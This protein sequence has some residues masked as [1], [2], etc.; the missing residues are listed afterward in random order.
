[1]QQTSD[2]TLLNG[3]LSYRQFRH[4]YRSG[5]EPVL[6]AAGVPAR[7]GE[8]VL[9]AGCGAGAGLLC[10]CARV[11]GLRGVGIEADTDTAA[12]AR[13]NW[14]VNGLD[15]LV[16]HRALLGE[17]PDGIGRFDHAMANPPWHR[18]GATASPLERRDLARRAR[19][20]L[21]DEWIVELA[22][23]LRPGGTLTLI[24]PAAQHARAGGLM[25]G[26]GGLGDVTLLPFWPKA[27]RTAKIVLMQGR[28]GSSGD[29]V[30]LPGLVLHQ[31]GGGFTASAERILRQGREL[32]I[33]RP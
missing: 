23:L 19:P 24:L 29:S 1:M 10:L 22:A 28:R 33:A 20:G 6:L 21:L 13:H 5:I 17:I 16:L 7:P 11:E 3:R 15:R 12:L 30:V 2:G 31:D 9:E 26:V 8:R 25:C 32:A 18:A 4:G 27:E 14:D